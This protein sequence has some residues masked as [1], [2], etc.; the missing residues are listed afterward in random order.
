MEHAKR[1]P[2][3]AELWVKATDDEPATNRGKMAEENQGDLKRQP[4]VRETQKDRKR[5]EDK[6][7]GGAAEEAAPA[8]VCDR[9]RTSEN[10]RTM[11]RTPSLLQRGE[12]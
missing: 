10:L 4:G 8:N 5:K 3:C 6:R 11:L 7:L 2:P 12:I 1:A 9:M